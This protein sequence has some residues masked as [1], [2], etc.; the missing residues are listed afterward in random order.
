M[1]Y[2]IQLCDILDY[3][4]HLSP[5]PILYQDLKPEH[6]ILCGNQVKIVD[7][8]VASFIT[9]SGKKIQIYGSDGFVANEAVHGQ[10]VGPAS[11]IYSLGRVLLF[12]TTACST[13]S[14]QLFDIIEKAC[15]TLAEERYQNA[16]DLKAALV[17]LFA[18]QKSAAPD[19]DFAC[20]SI[21]H[22]IQNIA[23]IGSR[24]GAGAT[25]F[26]VSL[27]SV[28]NKKGMFSAYLPMD[29]PDNLTS[30]AT[31]QLFW[32]EEHG[33]FY[34]EHFAGTPCY[35]NGIENPL[36][37]DCILVKDYDSQSLPLVL[38]ETFDLVFILLSAEAWDFSSTLRLG[39]LIKEKKN[40][41]LICNCNHQKA[42]KKCARHL[43]Q[44]VYCFPVDPDPFLVTRQ[45]ERLFSQILLQKGGTHYICNWWKRGK[46][47]YYYWTAW[48]RRRKWRDTS[49][50]CSGKSLRLKTRSADS[51]SRASQ[52]TGDQTSND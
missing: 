20:Q 7:F 2:G 18:Q 8:G 49:L 40:V 23:V 4:H 1:E 46:I 41:I 3:L 37:K 52:Q 42:A 11:D 9:G 44:P 47:S 38:T 50:R 29:C 25:H 35:G 24:P 6:I 14:R 26:A 43:H 17:T 33:I 45:K 51:L 16:A 32:R 27:V 21:S 5:Y 13:C 15:A 31:S 12:L 48:L 36:P 10:P 30:M 22:L 34:H 28:L 19:T 39:E